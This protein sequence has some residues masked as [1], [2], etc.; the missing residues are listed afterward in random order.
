MAIPTAFRLTEEQFLKL[1]ELS[2]DGRPMVWHVRKA[3]DAYLSSTKEITLDLPKQTTVTYQKHDPKTDKASN[4][5][6][7]MSYGY[8]FVNLNFRA[9]GE[10][11][12]KRSSMKKPISQKAAK[13]QIDMLC[14]YDIDTQR[15]IIN[16]SIQND[17]Q[18]LFEPKETVSGKPRLSLAERTEL[19]TAKVL[20]MCE[21][22]EAGY[23]S[24]AAYESALREQVGDGPGRRFSGG[25]VHGEL[26]TLVSENGETKR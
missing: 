23:S 16:K 2:K 10:W 22:E 11:C 15:E 3:I 5:F 12:S 20:V 9:W 21:A 13:S 6:N 8:S 24:V 19:E 7:P 1:K 26:L 4:K 25:S 14:K 18:G 17:Y